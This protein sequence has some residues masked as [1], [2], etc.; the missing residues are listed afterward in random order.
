MK[1][2]VA[3]VPPEAVKLLLTLFLSFLLGLEREEH[4]QA[5]EGHASFG[6]VRTFPLI[7]LLGYALALVSGGQILPLAVGFAVL[8]AFLLVSYIHKIQ[9]AQ[10]PGATTEVTGLVTFLVD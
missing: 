2:L 7:G 5:K 6:G 3:L 9:T 10:E 8:G 4:Q 1:E